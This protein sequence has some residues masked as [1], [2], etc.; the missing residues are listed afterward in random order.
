MIDYKTVIRNI[1]SKVFLDSFTDL[2]QTNI[3][4]C[5]KCFTFKSAVSL[6]DGYVLT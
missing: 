4:L 6:V 5:L 2:S 3:T 1:G